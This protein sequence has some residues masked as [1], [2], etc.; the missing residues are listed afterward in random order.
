[1]GINGDVRDGTKMVGMKKKP[2][3]GPEKLAKEKNSQEKDTRNCE[4]QNQEKTRKPAKTKRCVLL[5]GSAWSTETKYMEMYT[6]THNI[7]FIIAQRIRKEEM[8]EQFTK[9]AKQRWRMVEDAARITDDS[10]GREDC[11]HTSG[12]ILKTFDRPPLLR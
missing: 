5:N 2:W 1:M 10:A 12:G 7:F 4:K 11:K 3:K 6:D 9:E 8:E